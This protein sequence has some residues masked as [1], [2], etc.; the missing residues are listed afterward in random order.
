MG[1]FGAESDESDFVGPVA[2]DVFESRITEFDGDLLRFVRAFDGGHREFFVSGSDAEGAGDFHVQPAGLP[3]GCE[4]DE[5]PLPDFAFD[6]DLG[7][8]GSVAGGVGDLAVAVFEQDV[9]LGCDEFGSGVD[10]VIDGVAGLEDRPGWFHRVTGTF[11]CVLVGGVG[12]RDRQPGN[13]HCYR[14]DREDE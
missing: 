10:A 3:G 1:L 6:P 4:A 9:R 11:R 2:I 14:S 7:V 12:Y 13:G 5:G 8:V